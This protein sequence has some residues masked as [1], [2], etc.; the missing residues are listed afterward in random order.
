MMVHPSYS[1]PADAEAGARA[2]IAADIWKDFPNQY[3]RLAVAA[4]PC[5][6]QRHI[7]GNPMHTLIEYRRLFWRFFWRVK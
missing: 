7:Y 3:G 2:I 6:C 5:R 4:I 1:T